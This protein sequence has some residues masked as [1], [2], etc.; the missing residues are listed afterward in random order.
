MKRLFSFLL[1]AFA[2]PT[3]AQVAPDGPEPKPEHN[4]FLNV[5]NTPII[6]SQAG[7]AFFM[8]REING[9]ASSF[10]AHSFWHRYLP[11]AYRE[12]FAVMAAGDGIA[13]GFHK[14]RFRGHRWVERGVMIGTAAGLIVTGI[15]QRRAYNQGDCD[16]GAKQFCR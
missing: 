2:M 11:N 13:Y 14:A 10:T 7:G 5:W 15:R 8:A 16:L 4:F 3:F 1:L 6:L 9:N 12:S